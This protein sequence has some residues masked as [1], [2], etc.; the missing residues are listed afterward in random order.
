VD[1]FNLRQS[2]VRAIGNVTRLQSPSASAATRRQLIVMTIAAV[3]TETQNVFIQ[4][5]TLNTMP[6][7]H[8]DSLLEQ[9]YFEKVIPSLVFVECKDVST[10]KTKTGTATVIAHSGD[11]KSGFTPYLATASHL[12]PDDGKD[13]TEFRLTRYAFDDPAH[14]SSRTA[15][16]TLPDDGSTNGFVKIDDIV[17]HLRRLDIGWIRAPITCT[18]GEPWF[19][20]TN[21]SDE[22]MPIQRGH[23]WAGEGS[24]VAWAGFPG[25]ARELAGRPQPCFYRGVVSSWLVRDEFQLYL[26]DGHNTGGV[27]GGPVWWIDGEIQCPQLIGVISTYRSGEPHRHLP[28]LVCAIP[29]QALMQ[30][31]S[32][33]YIDKSALA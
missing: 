12:L 24:E 11:A 19:K 26:L 2:K 4:D 22:C 20:S 15:E 13:R 27:S 28:G 8:Y 1:D 18:D 30:R 6:A 9:V 25:I 29:I 31:I 14:P 3:W 10:G 16:F 33:D 23:K 21:P 5:H 17:P 7:T 32:P